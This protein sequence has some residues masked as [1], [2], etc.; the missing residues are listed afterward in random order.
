MILASIWSQL[1]QTGS[2]LLLS[3]QNLTHIM[4]KEGLKA[5]HFER[6]PLDLNCEHACQKMGPRVAA[7]SSNFSNEVV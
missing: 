2:L 6:P 1:S 5:S 7:V 4:F 3:K